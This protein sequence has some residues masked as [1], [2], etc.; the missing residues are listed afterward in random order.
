MLVKA[1][2][3][4]YYDHQI[5]EPGDVFEVD[6]KAI[7][8]LGSWMEPVKKDVPGKSAPKKQPVDDQ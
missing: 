8:A 7:K 5:R 4:G 3:R 6:L 2:Q 1:T